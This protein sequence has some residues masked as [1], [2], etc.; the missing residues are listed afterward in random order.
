VKVIPSNQT[1]IL[2]SERGVS[3]GRPATALGHTLSIGSG[4]SVL[5]RVTIVAARPD[6]TVVYLQAEYDSAAKSSPGAAQTSVDA[7]APGTVVAT[8]PKS[9]ALAPVSP[10]TPRNFPQALSRGVGLYASTQRILSEAPATI[11]IDVHA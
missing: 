7:A 4:D 3:G 10:Q 8:I 9:S 5:K 6:A 1:L 11:H 2:A